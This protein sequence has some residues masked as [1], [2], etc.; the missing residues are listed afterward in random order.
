MGLPL[1]YQ[2]QTLSDW[3]PLKQPKE[4]HLILLRILLLPHH[5]LNHGERL[6]QLLI[7]PEHLLRLLQLLQWNCRIDLRLE[8]WVSL[9]DNYLPGMRS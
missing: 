2:H 7:Q 9:V 6:H 5:Y 3:H 1:E 4:L 8:Y